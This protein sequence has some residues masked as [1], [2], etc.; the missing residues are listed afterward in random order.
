MKKLNISAFVLSD[1]PTS[2]GKANGNSEQSRRNYRPRRLIKFASLTTGRISITGR[3]NE[4]S[5]GKM[6]SMDYE[7]CNTVGDIE[8]QSLGTKCQV[9][10]TCDTDEDDDTLD[11][12]VVDSRDYADQSCP[13]YT[14]PSRHDEVQQFQTVTEKQSSSKGRN[15]M[16]HVPVSSIIR[17]GSGGV[18][19]V[20]FIEKSAEKTENALVARRR[21]IRLLIAVV[22][23]F[24]ICVLPS[25]LYHLYILFG[26][27]DISS[28]ITIHKILPTVVYLILYSNSALNPILYAFLS[29]NFRKS[30]KELLKGFKRK[31]P[32]KRATMR[33]TASSKTAN[34]MI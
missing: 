34:T 23:A 10:V 17:S 20:R 22:L 28:S 6:S 5:Q 19:A 27:P 21:V 24:A 25:H 3:Q 7:H 32:I 18:K 13:N 8:M 1:I 33:S 31:S 11:S 4:G 26:N 14:S 29:D 9:V 16:N 2:N 15:N 30:L 12:S